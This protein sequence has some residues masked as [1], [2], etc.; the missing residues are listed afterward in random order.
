MPPLRRTRK[1]SLLFVGAG[2]WPARGR[3]VCAPTKRKKR[4]AV[5][6]LWEGES[7]RRFAAPPLTRGTLAGGGQPGGL[8]GAFLRGHPHPPPSGAPSPLKGEG[9]RAADNR[10]YGSQETLP[11]LGR[12]GPW[13]SRQGGV[14]SSHPHPGLWV[15]PTPF[16]PSGHFPLTGGVG[17][18]GKAYGRVWDPPLRKDE[19]VPGYW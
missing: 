16:V 18:K 7:P 4:C 6:V 8:G 11:G 13:A 14:S 9:F 12:G 5:N 17:L 15:P 19:S 3:T 2:H 1:R 10:P